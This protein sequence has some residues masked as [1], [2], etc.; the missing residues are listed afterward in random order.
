MRS[1]ERRS[2]A[3]GVL[4]PNFWRAP[5]DNDFGA[6]L[7][8]KYAAIRNPELRLTDSTI[9]LQEGI[10]Y[11][12]AEYDF[13]AYAATLTVNYAI[14]N[15]GEIS[16]EQQVKVKGQADDK[17]LPRLF[18]FGML[19]AL[20][21]GLRPHRL[22]TAAARCENYADRKISLGLPRV[23]TA[24]RSTSSPIPTSGRRRPARRATCAGG[25]RACPGRLGG[26]ALRRMPPFSASALRYSPRSR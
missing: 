1:A 22:T 16:V 17:S 21:A 14:N 6:G 12:R 26:C 15:V 9:Q 20:P 13:P 19:M 10:A 2:G 8:R 18:R 5:T 24:R 25:S 7:Q 11:V 23:S 4:R 3:G